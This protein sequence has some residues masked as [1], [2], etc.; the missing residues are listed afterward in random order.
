M[1]RSSRGA[2]GLSHWWQRHPII[3]LWA[4]WLLVGAM[5]LF[6]LSLLGLVRAA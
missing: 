4:P 2:S 3:G 1:S 6:G 5:T